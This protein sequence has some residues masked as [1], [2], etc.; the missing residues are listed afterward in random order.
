M[1]ILNALTSGGGVALTGD[2]AGNLVLQSAGT[3]FATG[4]QYGIGLGTA[5]PSSGIGIAFPATQSASSD[6][7]TLD[8]Y[9]EGTWSPTLTT[10]FTSPT[11]SV[12]RGTYTKIGRQVNFAIEL[13]VN[14]GTRA[15]TL[16][17]IT[18]PFTADSSANSRAFG[19]YWTYADS[20]VNG[21]TTTNLPF[22]YIASGDAS[23]QFYNAAGSNF[24]GTDLNSATP[25]FYLCGSFVIG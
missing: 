23:M 22:L 10:G 21:S 5:V 12:Q 19:A 11:Y 7:N 3:T 14:G 8:D 6:A 25:T 1:S 24:N 15:G 20:S 13:T 16:L 2:T 9:E 17:R 4:N 18:L